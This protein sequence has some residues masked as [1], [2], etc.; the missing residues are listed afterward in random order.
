MSM[1]PTLLVYTSSGC[2]LPFAQNHSE[3]SIRTQLRQKR[4]AFLQL[5]L[6]ISLIGDV[7]KA[8]LGVPEAVELG[9]LVME[10]QLLFYLIHAEHRGG[11]EQVY[12]L[13]IHKTQ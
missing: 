9:V 5:I 10:V 12:E 13:V 1:T 2:Y 3:Q 11:K 8:T 7:V 6:H 4:Q